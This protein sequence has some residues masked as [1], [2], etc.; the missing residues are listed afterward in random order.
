MAKEKQSLVDMVRNG[1]YLKVHP[2]CVESHLAAGFQKVAEGIELEPPQVETVDAPP[3]GKPEEPPA[4]GK[5][6]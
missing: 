3:A 4:D 5:K 6:E 2:T 1:E